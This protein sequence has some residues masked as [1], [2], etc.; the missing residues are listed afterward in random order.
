M[1]IPDRFMCLTLVSLPVLFFSIVL[2]FVMVTNVS[3]RPF[4][5][6]KLPD[7]GKNFG[8][9][10]C[11]INPRGGGKLTSFGS[12][13]RRIGLKAGDIYTEDLGALDS[14]GDGVTNDQEYSSGTHPG[15]PESKPTS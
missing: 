14:D 11:H 12:D 2:S 1:K 3:G 5:L 8:C 7:R 15:D 6:V 10:T 13:Y 4:R 9:G